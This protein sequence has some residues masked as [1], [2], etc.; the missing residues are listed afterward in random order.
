MITGHRQNL[1][2]EL[3]WLWHRLAAAALI[4]ALAWQFPYAAGTAQKGGGKKQI[5]LKYLEKVKEG[6]INIWHH[7]TLMKTQNMK[8]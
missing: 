8:Y 1:N 4:Q 6:I 3:L 2:L 5:L 7:C